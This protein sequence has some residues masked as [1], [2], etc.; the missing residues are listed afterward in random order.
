LDIFE[1]IDMNSFIDFLIINE[2]C[3]NIDAYRLSTY[4]QISEEKKLKMGP[5]WDFNFSFGLTDYLNGYKSSG[6][7][8]SSMEEIPF[9]WE[10]LNQNKFFNSALTKR[11]KQLRSSTLSDEVVMEMVEKFDRELEIAQE[12]NF[13]KWSLLGQKE[14]WPNYYI[15]DTHQDEVNYLQRWISER[16]KWLDKQWKN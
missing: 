2:F 12:N 13:D 1:I 10:K 9:W 8:Y 5:I 11:W 7:V 15:G 16:A 14:V 3:K 6:F 4:F